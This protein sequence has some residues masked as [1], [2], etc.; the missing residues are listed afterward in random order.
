VIEKIEHQGEL[1]ALVLRAG[2]EQEGV[3]F[4]T[5]DDNSM[6]LGVL[7]HSKG[8]QIKSHVHKNSPRTINDVQEVLH[9]EY[10]EVEAGFYDDKG[11]KVK[12]VVLRPDD[13]I[14]L[15][16]GGHGFDILKDCKIIEVKQ[17]PYYGAEEDK[18]RI[19]AKHESF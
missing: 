2:Y 6:Q 3:N 10:G 15:I 16:S 18:E 8:H 12:S 17:G 9:I 1:L 13:T 11:V 4:I 7:K 5:P 19:K 14:L